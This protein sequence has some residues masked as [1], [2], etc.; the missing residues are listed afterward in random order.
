MNFLF[1]AGI[2][3]ALA[4]DA[5]AVSV[6]VSL[7]KLARRQSIRL[8]LHFGLFQLMMPIVG[9]LMGRSIVRCIEAVDHWVAFGLLFFIGGRMILESFKPQKSK[10]RDSSDPTKGLSLFMLSIATSI[11]ALTVGLSLGVLGVP[12]LLP[13]LV[14]GLVTFSLSIL[15]TLMGPLL[16]RAIG[17]RAEL[18]GGAVLIIIGIKILGEHL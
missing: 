13:A 15:G 16:G 11:D 17:K 4:M 2:A 6:G 5:F 7:E 9:W 8:A 10:H 12:I 18:I 3:V 14:I 1:M